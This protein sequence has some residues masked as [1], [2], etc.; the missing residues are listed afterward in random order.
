[1]S[2]RYNWKAD[3]SLVINEFPVGG[4]PV[5]ALVAEYVELRGAHSP[6]FEELRLTP[7]EAA[8]VTNLCAETARARAVEVVVAPPRLTATYRSSEGTYRV[9]RE[10][11]AFRVRAAA[12][13]VDERPNMRSFK[14]GSMTHVANG[15]CFCSSSRLGP[16]CGKCG[17]VRHSQG[18]PNGMSYQCERCGA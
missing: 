12:A 17:G 15:A 9:T 16:P 1:M 8:E 14:M 2:D 4:M 18:T 5:E 6:G 10:V 13:S 11:R 3:D 7:A